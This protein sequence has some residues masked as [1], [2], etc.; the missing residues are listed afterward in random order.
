MRYVNV[1]LTPEGDQRSGGSYASLSQAAEVSRIAK[2][3]GFRTLYRLRIRL[4]DQSSF[5][6]RAQSSAAPPKAAPPSDNSPAL[7]RRGFSESV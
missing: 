6:A 2:K 7:R 1:Y 5:C 3:C 4:K